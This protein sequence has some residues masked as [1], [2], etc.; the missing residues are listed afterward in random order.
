MRPRQSFMCA[1]QQKARRSEVHHE[2]VRLASFIH[3]CKK[4]ELTC[5]RY[6]ASL[7]Q[8]QL[9]LVKAFQQVF[10]HI[11]QPIGEDKMQK[12]SATLEA[13]GINPEH[14]FIHV[15]DN[16]ESAMDENPPMPYFENTST[17]H[18]PMNIPTGDADE[19]T[20]KGGIEGAET[21]H[22]TD[23]IEYTSASSKQPIRIDSESVDDYWGM[24][25]SW[26]QMPSS[27]R[28]LD[29][30]AAAVLPFYMVDQNFLS[31]SH[32]SQQLAGSLD[33]CW[34]AMLDPILNMDEFELC[35]T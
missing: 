25:D 1:Q 22:C 12:I 11:G 3:G 10:E 32:T 30:Q 5:Y 33:M 19:S 26:N 6:I 9:D 31:T 21:H 34:D 8:R 13:Q 4:T 2:G 16:A 29:E 14:F 28:E 27:N 20:E 15:R 23:M 24:N 7:E 18:D 35:T 17:S